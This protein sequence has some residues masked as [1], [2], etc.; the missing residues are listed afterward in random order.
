MERFEA[1]WGFI[2]CIA[3]GGRVFFADDAYRT[4]DELIEGSESA[5]IERRLEDGTRFRM[6]KIPHTAADLQRVAGP[7]VEGRSPRARRPVL[8]ASGGRSPSGIRTRQ[9]STA[10]TGMISGSRFRLALMFMP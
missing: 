10:G 1:F 4:E 7:R 8:L 6:V 3:P 5:T 9:V 2:V